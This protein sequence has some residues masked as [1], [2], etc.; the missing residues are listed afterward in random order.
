MSKNT[1]HTD[2]S[3]SVLDQPPKEQ[4]MSIIIAFDSFSFLLKPTIPN[5]SA[6]EYDEIIVKPGQAVAFTYEQLHAGG[7]H[8]GTEYI[9]RLFAYI[10]SGRDS[11]L[12]RGRLSK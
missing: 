12:P 11:A 6:R 2:Y 3:D 7:P 9:Y 1:F 10:V 5:A 4:P 8:T